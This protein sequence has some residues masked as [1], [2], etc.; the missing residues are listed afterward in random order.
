[1]S[2]TSDGPAATPAGNNQNNDRSGRNKNRNKNRNHARAPRTTRFEGKVEA[3]K[4][5]VYD[6]FIPN[7]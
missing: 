1:M 4:D 7:Q 6:I 5:Y 3:L 2:T